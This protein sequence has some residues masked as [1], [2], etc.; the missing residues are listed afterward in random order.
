[1]ILFSLHMQHV[2]FEI[3]NQPFAELQSSWCVKGQMLWDLLLQVFGSCN[4][5]W[6]RYLAMLLVLKGLK[7]GLRR[8][9]VGNN[10]RP[11]P[12]L[13]GNHSQSGIF[14]RPGYTVM[15]W[16]QGQRKWKLETAESVPSQGRP[17]SVTAHLCL[18]LAL[19]EGSSV[20]GC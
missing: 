16:T 14:I 9:Q 13:R 10:F 19:P 7:S 1:M 8:T 20:T 4:C 6:H 5:T 15:C 3:L 12:P 2:C 18:P 11:C 17:C